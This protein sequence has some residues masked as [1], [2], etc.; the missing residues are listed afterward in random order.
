METGVCIYCSRTID[1]PALREK[2]GK[3]RCK[4][5]DDCLEY[6][7]RVNSPDSP[8]D[9]EDMPNLIK[10][11]LSEAAER[12]PLY[13]T[14]KAHAGGS[15][16]A[17]VEATAAWAW[18]KSA[19]DALAS[20][21]RGK[22]RFQFHDGEN[23]GY[24]ISFNDGD[25]NRFFKVTIAPV[26][27]SRYALTVAETDPAA[28]GETLYREFIYTSYPVSGRDQVIQ[29]LCVVLLA[30]DGEGELRSPLLRQFRMDI[31]SRQ[32]PKGDLSPQ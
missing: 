4:N 21:Y 17:S 20:E 11:F 23:G 28:A 6:Q 27:R 30:F 22:T 31:E 12:I 16:D 15:G 19:L 26:S 18:L 9:P 1:L 14:A 10:S 25:Q 24:D 8:E 32:Y 5:E 7:T 13:K 29:D 2:G 3:Y